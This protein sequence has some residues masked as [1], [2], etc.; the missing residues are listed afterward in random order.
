MPTVDALRRSARRCRACPLWK[1]ATQTV[2]GEGP[3]AARIVMIGEQA[4]DREDI[5]GVPFVGPAG[6]LLDEALAAVGIEREALYVTN[7]GLDE[8]FNPKLRQT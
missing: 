2:F 8:V 5:E 1:P 3:D 7:V 6:R 4:G